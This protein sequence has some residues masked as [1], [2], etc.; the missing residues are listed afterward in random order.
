MLHNDSN[1][2]FKGRRFSQ[3]KSKA[4]KGVARICGEKDNKT[5]QYK[6][7]Q[8]RRNENS[9]QETSSSHTEQEQTVVEVKERR[10]V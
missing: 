1:G 6:L 10:K 5:R 8:M 4:K 3:V 7:K 9:A 2:S